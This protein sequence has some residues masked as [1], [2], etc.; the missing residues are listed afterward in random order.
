MK[1]KVLLF[2]WFFSVVVV[3]SIIAQDIDSTKNVLK[4][5]TIGLAISDTTFV[6]PQDSIPKRPPVNKKLIRR[7]T[8]ASALVPGLGQAF[9]KQIYK[10]PIYPGA[11]VFSVSTGLGYRS[12]FNNYTDSLSLET[13]LDSI[14]KNR[15]DQLRTKQNNAR[16]ISNS[17]FAA[18]GFMYAAN[19]FDAYVSAQIKER[20]KNDGYSPMLSAY[21][22]AA[23]PGLGQITNKQYWKAPLF[24]LMLSGTGAAAVYWY[25]KKQCHSKIYLN[26]IRY[27]FEDVELWEDCVFNSNRTLS[28]ADLL[29]YH[30]RY[31][32]NYE[33]FLIA[34][35]LAYF[36]NIA[37]ALVYSHLNNFDMDDSLSISVQ[38]V[39]M[40]LS[41]GDNYFGISLKLSL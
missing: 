8:L 3:H 19:I 6:E 40:P 20:T 18:A 10:T 22:S 11:M 13:G 27:N 4:S 37:D 26:R 1:F 32:R 30:E 39:F 17:A 12:I 35:G 25:D 7:A 29:G 38:P 9:N 41:A 24:W 34:T 5:D 2:L 31:K 23:L 28:D 14:A 21:R 36:L 16:I 33:I 15:R